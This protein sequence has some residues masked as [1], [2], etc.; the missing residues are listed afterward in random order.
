M[1]KPGRPFPP[2]T[3]S[4]AKTKAAAQ[5]LEQLYEEHDAVFLERKFIA[6]YSPQS[7]HGQGQFS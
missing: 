6:A 5:K 7:S 2:T 3:P 4:L 1:P